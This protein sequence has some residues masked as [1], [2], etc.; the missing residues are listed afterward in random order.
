MSWSTSSATSARRVCAHAAGSRVRDVDGVGLVQ[1][2]R[3]DG[4]VRHQDRLAGR[5][6]R[7]AG[8]CG[9]GSAPAARTRSRR[10]RARSRRRSPRTRPERSSGRCAACRLVARTRL[11]PGAR[12]SARS[13]R[14]ARR[15]DPCSSRRG[16]RAGASGRRCRS[17]P[18]TTPAP[19]S[20]GS[21]PS[22]H[23]GVQPQRPAGPTPVSTSTVVPPERSRYEVQGMPPLRAGERAPDRRSC[24]APSRR[25]PGKSSSS[26][27]SSADSVDERDELDRADYQRRAHASPHGRMRGG[28]GSP[29]ASCHDT[30]GLRS[31]PIRS[32]SASITSPG[33]R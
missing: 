13:E 14:R 33:F 22:S 12:R 15:S 28:A 23:S 21:S 29:C 7:S 18:G 24:S 5:P 16:R 20:A 10:P 1:H 17:R 9:P 11:R 26:S 2:H 25:S 6:T 30:T 27:P 31:T 32:I 19:A 4:R 3:V 8:P